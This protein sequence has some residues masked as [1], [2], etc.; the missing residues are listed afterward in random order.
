MS[1]EVVVDVKMTP[2]R[3]NMGE[4]RK[5][6]KATG[7]FDLE[8]T[9]KDETKIASVTI[10]DERFS[11]KRTSGNDTEGGSFEVEFRGEKELGRIRSE[12]IVATTGETPAEFSI[13]VSVNV[14][15]NL[16]YTQRLR[17]TKRKGEYRPR[18]LD[19][20][21]RSGERV[22]VKKIKDP[23]GL[24]KWTVEETTNG[25]ARVHIEVDEAKLGEGAIGQK[26]TLTVHTND[27][28]QPKVEI[29]YTILEAPA[30]RSGPRGLKGE[31]TPKRA[32]SN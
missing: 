17:F 4:L 6:E 1:G 12:V 32:G 18:N 22:E 2:K 29:E 3:V 13:P 16:R 14:V 9:E 26:N 19:I 21:M 11:L 30:R 28:E 25:R 10:E 7:K 23:A 20:S 31:P 24:L 8:V 15:A 27:R 5:G